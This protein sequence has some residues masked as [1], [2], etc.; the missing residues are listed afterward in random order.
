MEG[1]DRRN[2]LG[3][4]LIVAG[5]AVIFY[6]LSPYLPSITLPKEVPGPEP[7]VTFNTE[8]KLSLGYLPG[9]DPSIVS[10]DTQRVGD[11]L[12]SI[13]N[14]TKGGE[15]MIFP[16]SGKLKLQVLAPDGRS[17]TM[18]KNVKIELGETKAFYFTWKTKQTGT[19]VLTVSLINGEGTTVDQKQVE[20]GV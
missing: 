4:L 17:V 10:I 3:I 15:L 11:V 14:Q 8:V 19:H 20:V 9:S 2:L 5:I 12:S 18:T 7:A 16:W 6:A 1:K 13:I